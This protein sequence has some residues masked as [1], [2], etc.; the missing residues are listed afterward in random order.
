MLLLRDSENLPSHDSKNPLTAALPLRTTVKD[1]VDALGI[2]SFHLLNFKALSVT[3][4]NI[5]TDYLIVV[6]SLL[7]LLGFSLCSWFLTRS[8]DPKVKEKPI[9]VCKYILL[10]LRFNYICII[11]NITLYMH[12]IICLSKKKNACNHLIMILFD[13]TLFKTLFIFVF[14]AKYKF[15]D[16]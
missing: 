8:L 14:N 9:V 12:V 15:S 16:I 13:V 2:I 11:C 1:I 3:M 4:M 5:I 6:I 10:L 7:L